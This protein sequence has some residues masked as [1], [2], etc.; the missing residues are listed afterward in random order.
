[1]PATCRQLPAA[2]RQ[3]AGRCRGAAC[4]CRGVAGPFWAPLKRATILVAFFYATTHA[5]SKQ[6]W[7][8]VTEMQSCKGSSASCGPPTLANSIHAVFGLDS[9]VIRRRLV[10]HR[11]TASS[12]PPP[13]TWVFS[14]R[15]HLAIAFGKIFKCTLN[16]KRTRSPPARS[17]KWVDL[18]RAVKRK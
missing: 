6:C 2:C 15:L 8:Q 3:A 12:A 5:S 13:K 16:F 10:N 18:A 7:S 11:L 1:M 14:D 4:R 9:L 17:P